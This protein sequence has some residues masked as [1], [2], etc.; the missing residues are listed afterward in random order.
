[1]DKRFRLHVL[2]DP[3]APA[4]RRCGVEAMARAVLS[5]GATILQLRSKTLEARYLVEAGHLLRRVVDQFPG[6]R[7]FVND[8]AD[9][10]WI[11]RADGVHVGQDD[12][13]VDDVR[14]AW[15][16]LLVGLSVGNA[17]EL[18]RAQ[19]GRAP[20]YIGVGPVFATAS[21]KDAGFP[22]GP[23]AIARMKAAWPQ[24]PVVAIGGV[25]PDNVSA[26]WQAGADG[27]AVIGS[28]FDAPDPQAACRGL[29]GQREI[30]G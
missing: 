21:K 10:A 1:M 27:V 7:Y 23:E 2:L 22:I 28:V 12:L 14:L 18:A 4:V 3:L 5:G 30:W 20:D 29:L 9:V 24:M 11:T 26:V 17:E 16:D 8:R 15:P 6:S 25:A 13:S 19:S